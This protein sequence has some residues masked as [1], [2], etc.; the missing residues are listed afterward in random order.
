LHHGG[1]TPMITS[2]DVP[3]THLLSTDLNRNTPVMAEPGLE[4]RFQLRQEHFE[5]GG[6]RVDVI[7]PAASE[8]LIDETEFNVDERLPYW[9]ELWPSARALAR[10]LLDQPEVSGPALE[11][12]CGVALP[13]LVLRHRG[14]EVLATD[15][16]EDALHFAR[17]N[18]TRNGLAGL[19]TR[20]VDWRT[21]PAD[22][23]N[24]NLILASDV[25]YEARNVEPLV[26]ALERLLAPS[27]AALIAD[28]GRVYFPGFLQRL[29]SGGWT[30]EHLAEIA[31]P[32]PAG[33]ALQSQITIVR[34]S[35]P[36]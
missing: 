17:A 1:G 16:Y 25:L 29:E 10:H 9:A 13:S 26:L 28:P 14:I 34:L 27:G 18:G 23:G 21:P 12:G 36:T 4:S 32:S 33:V 2:G 24:F 35:R 3:V 20:L 7:L 31:E 15:F 22:L 5:H 8:E 11:L 30:A 19:A 6:F